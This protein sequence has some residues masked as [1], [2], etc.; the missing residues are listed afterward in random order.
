MFLSKQLQLQ[1]TILKTNYLHS[2]VTLNTD[3]VLYE[4]MCVRVQ[5]S[6]CRLVMRVRVCPYGG[7]PEYS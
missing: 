7:Q 5:V 3:L 6:G 1:I 4:S 2:V